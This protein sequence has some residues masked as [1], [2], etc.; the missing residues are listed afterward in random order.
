MKT[1]SSQSGSPLGLRGTGAP[2]KSENWPNPDCP[3]TTANGR[4][5]PQR[6][7]LTLHEDAEPNLDGVRHPPDAALPFNDVGVAHLGVG[8]RHLHGVGQR[9]QERLLV[10]RDHVGLREPDRALDVDGPRPAVAPRPR[11]DATAVTRAVRFAPRAVRAR[12]RLTTPSRQAQATRPIRARPGF[13]LRE[14]TRLQRRLERNDV[15]GRLVARAVGVHAALVEYGAI[16]CHHRRWA[17]SMMTRQQWPSN[18]NDSMRSRQLPTQPVCSEFTRL[19]RVY[20]KTPISGATVEMPLSGHEPGR[21]TLHVSVG[22]SHSEQQKLHWF[23]PST[24]DLQNN[25]GG[26]TCNDGWQQQGESVA[27]K[28]AI[29][30][31]ADRVAA[32][33][34]RD[35][36]QDAPAE[37]VKHLLGHPR[38]R[39]LALQG[40]PRTDALL[41]SSGEALFVGPEAPAPALSHEVARVVVLAR[42]QD[43]LQLVGTVGLLQ[44][45]HHRGHR[46]VAREVQVLLLHR[47]VKHG[48]RRRERGRDRVVR[49][50]DFLQV[51]NLA[52]LGRD[53]QVVVV[54]RKVVG[55]AHLAG[56][57]QVDLDGVDRVRSVGA[58]QED[59]VGR[60]QVRI[61][62][63]RNAARVLHLEALVR[64]QMH[65]RER[66]DV[67]GLLVD[68]RDQ[69]RRQ[70]LDR[71]AGAPEVG[72][73]EDALLDPQIDLARRSLP[74]HVRITRALPHALQLRPVSRTA[75]FRCEVRLLQLVERHD[76]VR[77]S[78]VVLK[79][80]GR[81][82][83]QPVAVGDAQVQFG[84]ALEGV[85]PLRH[86]EVAHD[87]SRLVRVLQSAP[88]EVDLVELLLRGVDNEI[89]PRVRRVRG[90]LP[91]GR[92]DVHG[93]RVEKQLKRSFNPRDWDLV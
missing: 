59:P 89:L 74:R 45:L 41:E 83:I 3:N 71:E 56:A 36:E 16:A 87:R 91:P 75:G 82:P 2:M 7:P 9:A 49:Q 66:D 10:K 25:G 46:G 68:L 81:C 88:V 76:R 93:T 21:S 32:L 31:D 19:K 64:E 15:A 79:P 54:A 42:A 1:S 73:L 70:R 35:Q 86:R 33:L 78:G 58:P 69:P 24:A 17:S 27:R 62:V 39:P 23:W 80:A 50:L 72:Q 29:G 22:A 8:P 55:V 65:V 26:V 34:R 5:C 84:V 43:A 47:R 90:V 57:M 53:L 61:G 67:H 4:G 20:G 14:P 48:P 85:V 11:V 18:M 12:E 52:R 38:S 30:P 40:A 60:G 44:V 6:I 28:I 92:V 63:G 77:R 37:I 51:Q 13:R